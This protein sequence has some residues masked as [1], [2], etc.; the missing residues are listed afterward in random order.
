MATIGYDFHL[1]DKLALGA[2]GKYTSDLFVDR[3]SDILSGKAGPKKGEFGYA[4]GEI[5]NYNTSNPFFL[6]LAFQNF[7]APL[8][9]Q[10]KFETLYPN[11]ENPSR[12]TYQGI[13][14]AVDEFRNTIK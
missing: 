4:E 9:V 13:A 14:S 8:E 3:V 10:P 12:R 2:L 5:E 11:E 1:N 7:Q 6:Y